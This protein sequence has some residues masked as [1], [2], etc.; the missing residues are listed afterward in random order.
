MTMAE[1]TLSDSIIEKDNSKHV[2]FSRILGRKGERFK[3]YYKAL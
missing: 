2:V 3:Y 1:E